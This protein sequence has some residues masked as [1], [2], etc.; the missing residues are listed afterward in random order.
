MA[1][2]VFISVHVVIQSHCAWQV[3]HP[4]E[5]LLLEVVSISCHKDIISK[6]VIC[7]V[8]PGV[9]DNCKVTAKR[10]V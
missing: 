1:W 2:L 3:V 8:L 6:D 10:I 9:Q 5:A 4:E 7:S